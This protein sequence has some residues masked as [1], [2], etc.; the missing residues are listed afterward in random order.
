MSQPFFV[1]RLSRSERAK[2]DKLRADPPSVGVYRR[3]QAV[4]LSAG[5]QKVE[6]IAE[7]VGRDRTTVSRWLHTFEANGICG[8]FPGRSTGRPPKVDAECQA[9]L[10]EA[11]EQNPRDLGYPFTRWTAALL[12]EHVYRTVH[13]RISP[14]TIY[15]VFKR[16]GF[17]Y[18]RPKLDLTHRQDAKDV[19]RAKRQKATALKKQRS[20]EVIWRFSTVTKPSST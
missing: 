13:V 10:T 14:S 7:I 16:L 6:Q 19:A 17:R 11:V 15:H 3:T 20:A 9:A 18:G 5:G 12:A 2:I 8:L 1:R 4:H